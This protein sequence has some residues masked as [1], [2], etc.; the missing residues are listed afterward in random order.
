MARLAA[1]RIE[2][3][4]DVRRYPASRRHPHFNREVLEEVL[5]A[6]GVRY[7]WFEP[8]GGRRAGLP[9]RESPNL[10][11]ETDGFRGYADYALGGEFQAAL[12][13][14]TGWMEGG[15]T[16]I[17]CAELLWWQCH[18]RLIADQ[19]VA[20]GGTVYHVRDDTAAE[21]HALWDLARVTPEGVFYPPT[22]AELDLE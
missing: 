6:R 17:L 8:L 2:Q 15:R 11:I 14:L 1:H 22:Q 9:E 4:A 7:R 12:A 10:G 18:R 21:R 16:A 3:V 13:G 5:P 19:L 20:R